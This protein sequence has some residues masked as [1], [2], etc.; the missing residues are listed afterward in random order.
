MLNAVRRQSAH[1][2][3]IY[4]RLISKLG[5]MFETLFLLQRLGR[6]AEIFYFIFYRP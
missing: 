1:P 3:P 2:P 5:A 6:K 4:F